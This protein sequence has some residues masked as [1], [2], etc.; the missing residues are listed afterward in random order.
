MN[1]T[2]VAFFTGS[3][4]RTAAWKMHCGYGYDHLPFM[5]VELFAATANEP[6]Y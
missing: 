2:L 1:H 6:E 5:Q 3:E 4:Q